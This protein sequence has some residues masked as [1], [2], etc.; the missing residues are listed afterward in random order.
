M[1]KKKVSKPATPPKAKSSAEK[2]V[3]CCGLC[4]NTKKLK[5]TECCGNWVCDDE[6]KY[7]LFSYSQ[8]S[9]SRNHRRYTLCS[10]HF[11]EGH[12]GDWNDCEKCREPFDTE[13]YVHMGTNEYNF[14]ILTDP[15]TFEPTTCIDCGTVID[16]GAGGFSMSSDGYRCGRCMVKS[17]GKKRSGGK[18]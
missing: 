10:F 17:T 1:A 3:P 6:H 13:M 15:P 2:P 9:C 14:E 11:N 8:N 16:M 7:V 4:G 5:R 18:P 12:D